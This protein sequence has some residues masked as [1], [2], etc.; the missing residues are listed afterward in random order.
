MT[1]GVVRKVYVCFFNEGGRAD[2]TPVER[3]AVDIQIDGESD[4]RS[5]EGGDEGGTRRRRDED[6]PLDQTSLQVRA[7]ASFKAYQISIPVSI[8]FC[9]EMRSGCEPM[10]LPLR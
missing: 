4:G 3:F 9:Q 5:D 10:H 6:R 2:R 1:D 7:A 8:P